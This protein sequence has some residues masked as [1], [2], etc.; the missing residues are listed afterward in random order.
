MSLWH[1]RQG[2]RQDVHAPLLGAVESCT[3]EQGQKQRS[4]GEVYPQDLMTPFCHPLCNPLAW[5]HRILVWFGV[6]TD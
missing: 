2:T 1:Q 4:N 6:R 3:E 5:Q